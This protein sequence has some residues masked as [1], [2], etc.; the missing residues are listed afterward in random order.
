MESPLF[1]KNREDLQKSYQICGQIEAKDPLH[2]REEDKVF[3]SNS[4]NNSPE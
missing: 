2:L 4:Q 3:Y 1:D